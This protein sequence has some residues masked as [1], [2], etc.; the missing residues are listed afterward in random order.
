MNILIVQN[1]RLNP[2]GILEECVQARGENPE[3]IIPTQGDKLPESS[4]D[5]DGL[6][7]MGGAMNAEDD[8][9]YP[10]LSKVVNVIHQFQAE[11]K[12][13]MGVCL[14][15]QLIARAFGK[16]IYR[17]HVFEVGFNPVFT[18]V[19]A[20]KDSVLKRCA[21]K[22]YLMQW[23]FDTFDLPEVATLLM[24][25]QI[26]CNQAFRI[27]TNI[28]GFQFHLEVTREVVQNW[29]SVDNKFITDNYPDLPERLAQEMDKYID[30]AN[31]FCR[32]VG[33]GWLDLVKKGESVR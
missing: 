23:H 32:Q 21:Q 7:I 16:R 18:L 33:N 30:D 29:L 9:G 1:S 22:T 3:I 6:I 27:G 31:D 12:P 14:G 28:Y 2:P 17:N 11:N 5:F 20:L 8:A 26:C 19:T 4:A 10:H 24:S 13:I 15:A 25:N